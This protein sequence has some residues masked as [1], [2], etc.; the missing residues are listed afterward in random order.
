MTGIDA[1]QEWPRIN[2][3]NT[4]TAMWI[5]PTSVWIHWV[6]EAYHKTIL[7][8]HFNKPWQEL[9]FHVRICDC[10]D[11]PFTG[12]NEHSVTL[13]SV[14]PNINHIYY[15][16]LSTVRDYAVDFG[17]ILPSGSFF[18]IL[19]GTLPMHCPDLHSGYYSYIKFLPLGESCFSST[20]VE[21]EVT[22]RHDQPCDNTLI[23]Y[24]GGSKKGVN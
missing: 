2:D 5:N 16:S 18:A 23:G 9:S 13:L 3:K 24:V 6:L 22:S 7:S 21:V 15:R 12:D 1:I 10:T 14:P 19:H 11:K 17:L 8:N 20:R 4:L